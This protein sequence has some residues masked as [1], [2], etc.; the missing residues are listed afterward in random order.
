VLSVASASGFAFPAAGDIVS[1][2]GYRRHPIL[3]TVRLHA[4]I[5]IDAPEGADVWASKAGQVILAGW[6]G[7]YGNCVMIDHGGGMVTLYG[8]LSA[9]YVSE[10]QLVA[11]GTVIGAVGATG[12]ATG[13]HLHFETRVDGEPQNPLLFVG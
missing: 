13:P 12:L 3:G 11:Q 7:G 10:G 8:H 2:F 1:E 4:G 6:N 5:D 9:I